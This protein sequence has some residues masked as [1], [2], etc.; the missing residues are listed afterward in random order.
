MYNI[1]RENGYDTSLQEAYGFWGHENERGGR[2][3]TGKG[4]ESYPPF[5]GVLQEWRGN[6]T[7]GKGGGLCIR[8]IS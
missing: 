5:F 8:V 2:S 6:G 1:K 7:V 4:I 3:R